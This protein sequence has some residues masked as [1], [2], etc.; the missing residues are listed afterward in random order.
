[1]TRWNRVGE[2]SVRPLEVTLRPTTTR[3]AIALVAFGAL[4]AIPLPG[5]YASADCAAPAIRFEDGRSHIRVAPGDSVTLTGTGFVKGCDD[6]GDSDFGCA[7]PQYE[8]PRDDIELELRQGGEERLL[9]TADAENE[10][11]DLGRVSW[12]ATIP[13][14]AIAGRATLVPDGGEPLTVQIVPE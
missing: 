6:G 10:C 3:A 4:V 7:A 2:R 9:A 12:S 5:D 1:V 11:D 13:A 14:D 8:Q